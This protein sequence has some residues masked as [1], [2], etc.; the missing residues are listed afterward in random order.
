MTPGDRN[1]RLH[2]VRVRWLELISRV[3]MSTL[4]SRYR[5]HIFV[6][7]CS[8]LMHDALHKAWN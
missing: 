7:A 1:M 6:A 5:P 2:A 8:E 3:E 4:N